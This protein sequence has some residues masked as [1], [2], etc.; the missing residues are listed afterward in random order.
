M[1]PLPF[2]DESIEIVANN[3]RKIKA[4]IPV[5]FLMENISYY[6]S[7]PGS[8]MSEAEF[9]S[10]VVEVA[11]CGLLLDLT[12]VHTN[13][14]NHGYDPFEFLRSLPLERVVEIHVAGGLM[15]DGVLIDSHSSAV[16]EAVWDLLRFV[17]PRS[18]V[19]GVVLERDED[20][21][22]LEELSQELDVARRI[23]AGHADRPGAG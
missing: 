3:I 21:P 14:I 22:S 19:K 2:S 9:I 20:V 1:T 8:T 15:M 7:I 18:P 4:F 23:L 10:R 12:N 6:F 13:A 17:L 16:P 5:P 11:D